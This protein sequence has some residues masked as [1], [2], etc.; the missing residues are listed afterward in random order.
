MAATN[1]LNDQ[2]V[3]LVQV[4]D[5]REQALQLVEEAVLREQALQLVEDAVLRE[6][7]VQLEEAVLL[8][9]EVDVVRR[10]SLARLQDL[11]LAAGATRLRYQCR[12]CP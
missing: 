6:Q 11:A 9:E 10:K 2:E 12:E 3:L 4:A 1:P 8:E 7:E 5:L